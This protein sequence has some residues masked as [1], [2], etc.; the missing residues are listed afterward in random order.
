MY[1]LQEKRL[2]CSR[3]VWRLQLTVMVVDFGL[4]GGLT[5][6]DPVLIQGRH[7]CRSELDQDQ[8]PILAL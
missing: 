2:K 7:T 8:V 1:Y 6:P 5:Q 3:F 4:Q